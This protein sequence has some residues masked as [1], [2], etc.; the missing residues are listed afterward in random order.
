[1]DEYNR[2]SIFRN[3]LGRNVDVDRLCAKRTSEGR[4]KENRY[5]AVE[6][7]GRHICSP[8]NEGSLT[9]RQTT[10]RAFRFPLSLSLSSLPSSCASVSSV[11]F[12]R[13]DQ[14]CYGSASRLVFSFR[15]LRGPF[16]SIAS[17]SLLFF[18]PSFLSFSFLFY[19]H[20][21]E[22][23]R[24]GWKIDRESR[25]PSSSLVRVEL[26]IIRKRSLQ[27]IRGAKEEFSL[28]RRES[29]VGFILEYRRWRNEIR[30]TWARKSWPPLLVRILTRRKEKA[31]RQSSGWLIRMEMEH[32]SRVEFGLLDST[33]D[34]TYPTW[35]FE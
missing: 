29:H 13:G 9:C 8:R 3:V 33:N 11:L 35:S 34:Y 16:Q 14:H 21:G 28:S 6:G 19:L 25:S 12:R 27:G 24:N 20:L 5:L 18:L 1:M 31:R 4:G 30:T 23:Q 26:A 17:E 7:I 10:R 15:R 2:C 22:I 32:G